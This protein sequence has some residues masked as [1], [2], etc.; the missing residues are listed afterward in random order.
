MI[1]RIDLRGSDRDPATVL[2]RAD[3]ATD[4]ADLTDQ[5]RPI[6]EAVRR[7]G[8]AAVRHYTARFDQVELAEVRVPKQ[9]LATALDRLDPAV[10]AALTECA[11]RARAVHEVQRRPDETVTVAPGGTVTERWL[12]ARRV[13][14]YVPGG[15]LAYPS[16]VVMNVVPAQV[17]G[18]SSLAVASP[19][20]PEHGGLPHPAILGACALLGVEEVYSVG[21]AQA[22]AMLAFGTADCP[23][24]DLISGP[25]NAYVTAAKRLV[26][27]FVGVDAEAGPTEIAILA[28]RTAR[29][30][31]V[32]AD[33]IA[34]AEHDER[35][36]CLLVT[37]DPGLLDATVTELARQLPAIP[38]RARCQAALRGQSAAVLVDDLDAGLVLIEAWAPE[39][40]EIITADAADRAGRVRNAGAVFVGPYSPVSL[41]DYLAGSN[42]VLPTGGTARFS[43]G[44]SVQSFL[45]CVH[46][47]SYDEPA[48]AAAAPHIDAL[49]DAEGLPGHVAAV[50]ARVPR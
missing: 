4:R 50:R 48:L 8:S 34:Q 25:G 30:E 45:R 47:V 6:V 14:V 41:G 38:H 5:V 49:G 17:A 2:P 16:S 40:L 46:V 31:H 27:G 35:A 11:R 42:H 22:V 20:K 39:H 3:R 37:D 23:P 9:A 19:P 12:P 15:L 24:V 44:L 33:L 43:G 13:G 32:A 28:D 1:D 29:P 26:K 21:G 10:R 36:A 18:V 7:D